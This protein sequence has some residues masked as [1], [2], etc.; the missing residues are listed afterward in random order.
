MANFLDEGS[1]SSLADVLGAQADTAATG[2]TNEYA[3]RKRKEAALA[4]STGRLNSG[5]QNY[6]VADTQASELGD[7]GNVY[8]SLAGALGQVTQNDYLTSRAD[9]RNRELAL[10]VAKLNKPSDLASTMGMVGSGI[11]LASK[12]A[13]IYGGMG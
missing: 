8:G 7:L 13:A 1:G 3:K 4:A 6:T 10:L 12:G 5:V 11:N 9:D 2:I